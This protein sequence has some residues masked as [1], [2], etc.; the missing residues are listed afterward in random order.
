MIDVFQRSQPTTSPWVQMLPVLVVAAVLLLEFGTPT[1]RVAPSLLT[2]SLAVFALFLKPREVIGW[3]LAL[4]VPVVGSLLLISNAGVPEQ[5]AVVALRTAAFLVV[6]IMA[7]GLS[8][9]RLQSQNQ[10][11]S[12]VT[13]DGLWTP[14]AV[15]EAN[16][17]I[18]FANRSG[19][20]LL[21]CTLRQ[22]K[23]STLF[24]LLSHPDRRGRSIEHYLG[25]FE[26][27][28]AAEIEMTLSL[29]GSPKKVKSIGSIIEIDGRKLLV[30]QLV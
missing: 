4:L 21:G 3:G 20:N 26:G 2:V 5:P 23:D 1:L 10:V 9:Y 13:P 29:R 30:S 22:A 28:P 27:E 24:S 6:A 8:R 12:L 25:H 7:F 16:G 17:N 15:S 19:C 18:N 11:N 14:L